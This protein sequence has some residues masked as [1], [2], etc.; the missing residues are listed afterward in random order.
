MPTYGETRSTL[1]IP[2][3]A[4][5]A[6]HV[7]ACFAAAAQSSLFVG[8]IEPTS[9]SDAADA[10]PPVTNKHSRNAEY[11]E[12]YPRD[13]D[14][15]CCVSCCRFPYYCSSILSN[16]SKL[17]SYPC[18]HGGDGRGVVI[19]L[20]RQSLSHK[21]SKWLIFKLDVDR[22]SSRGLIALYGKGYK[23]SPW[24]CRISCVSTIDEAERTC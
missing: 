9:I 18:F 20:R 21:A 14:R 11:F 2:D 17:R 19:L 6:T 12:V 1:H 23:Y 4:T 5:R 22:F 3:N 15:C 16:G 7:S 13:T 8:Q 10:L 24:S